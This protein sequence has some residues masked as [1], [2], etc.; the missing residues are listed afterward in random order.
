[1]IYKIICEEGYMTNRITKLKYNKKK[2]HI[3]L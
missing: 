1:M 3:P 2:I